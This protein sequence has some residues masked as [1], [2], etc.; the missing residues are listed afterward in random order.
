MRRE[1][2]G[3]IMSISFK[4]VCF[5]K[6]FTKPLCSY[7]IKGENDIKIESFLPGVVDNAIDYERTL[8]PPLS[9]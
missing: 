1:A 7:R 6:E 2:Y 8:N 4:W 3:A 9:V 5:L